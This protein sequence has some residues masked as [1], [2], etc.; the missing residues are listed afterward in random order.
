[1]IEGERCGCVSEYYVEV[2][3]LCA[4]L[5]ESRI[6]AEPV[7]RAKEE[8]GLRE[9]ALPTHAATA[10]SARRKTF[11]FPVGGY[12]NFPR[13]VV[14]EKISRGEENTRITSF[15]FYFAA[16][17]L[18][19][20]PS[21]PPVHVPPGYQIS[22]PCPRSLNRGPKGSSVSEQYCVVSAHLVQ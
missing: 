22:R 12:R 6:S 3:L 2:G 7:R 14:G 17:E 15:C 9:C 16:F 5:E 1:M 21:S 10:I 11:P 8:D 18:P 4:S 13:T 19:R 20:S